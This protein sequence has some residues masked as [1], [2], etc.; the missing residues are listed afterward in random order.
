MY[1]L[2]SSRALELDLPKQQNA[3]CGHSLLVSP[4]KT[5]ASNQVS[6]TALGSISGLSTG[7]NAKAR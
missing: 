4:A 3:M 7:S 6:T 2:V 5:A 1:S